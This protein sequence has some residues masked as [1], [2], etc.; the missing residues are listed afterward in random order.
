M[1]RRD[2]RERENHRSRNVTLPT[3]GL[4]AGTRAAIGAGAALLLAERLNRK[5]RKRVGW[6]L[7]T[8]GALS[9][10][11]L[12]ARMVRRQAA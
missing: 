10:F 1:T 7:L 5:R 8:V 11:P 6:T 12:V 2:R 4:F 9:T 3:L